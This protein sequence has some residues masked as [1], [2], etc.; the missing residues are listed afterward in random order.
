MAAV[1]IEYILPMTDPSGVVHRMCR[2]P[3]RRYSAELRNSGEPARKLGFL[4]P[5]AAFL[6]T[7]EA[8][9]G[10]PAVCR[11]AYHEFQQQCYHLVPTEARYPALYTLK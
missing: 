8:G 11:L 10:T 3:A 9:M 2:S 7:L 1:L 4:A 6:A 5:C